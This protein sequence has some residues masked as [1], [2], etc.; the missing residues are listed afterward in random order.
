[1]VKNEFGVVIK[2]R[3]QTWEELLKFC[4]S[5]S[6]VY[7]GLSPNGY[8]TYSVKYS[9]KWCVEYITARPYH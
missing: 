5:R 9:D 2:K 1:M 6:V 8:F 7:R 4:N 3:A